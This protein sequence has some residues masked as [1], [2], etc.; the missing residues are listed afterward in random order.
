[1]SL[2][3]A[4]DLQQVFADADS[5]WGSAEFARAAEGT[6]RLLPTFGERVVT[7]RFVAP[8][9]PRGGWIPYYR[10]W[11]F[12]LV[13]ESDRL[14]ELVVGFEGHRTISATTFGKWGP[15]LEAE[16]DDSRE[17]VLTG[18][19]TDCCVLSTALAA[20]DAGVR[21]RVVADACAG[22]SEADHQRALEAMALYAPLIEVTTLD[23]VLAEV[24]NRG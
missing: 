15:E 24:G 21:V 17:L 20:A 13:P 23:V 6:R 16:L 4:I 9:R 7:T 3:V 8:E 11:P 1:M 2:L 22:A 5:P 12:A 19:A 14:Y 18:V 10:K